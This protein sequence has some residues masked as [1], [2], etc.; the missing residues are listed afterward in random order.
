[1]RCYQ[2]A[3]LALMPFSHS[4]SLDFENV[5]LSKHDINSLMP[6]LHCFFVEYHFNKKAKGANGCKKI[7]SIFIH[8]FPIHDIND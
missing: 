4:F 6:F 1:M 8:R 7:G 5:L 3:A 2:N